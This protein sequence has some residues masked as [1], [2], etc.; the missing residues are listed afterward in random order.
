VAG[1]PGKDIV[2]IPGWLRLLYETTL[3]IAAAY[4]HFQ[5]AINTWAYLFVIVSTLHYLISY[6]RIT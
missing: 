5:L 3:F 6:N 4:M 2:A 1:D